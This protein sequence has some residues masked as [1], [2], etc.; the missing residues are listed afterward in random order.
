MNRIMRIVIGLVIITLCTSVTRGVLEPLTE[1]QKQTYAS[2]LPSLINSTKHSTLKAYLQSLAKQKPADSDTANLNAWLIRVASASRVAKDVNESSASQSLTWYAVPAMSDLM[3]LADRYPYDG[4]YQGDL[5]IVAARGEYEPV[6]FSLFAFTDLSKVELEVTDL[7]SSSGQTLSRDSVDLKVVK[8]WYQNATGWYSYFNDVGQVLVPELLL[9]DENLIRVDT[10]T[11]SNYARIKGPNGTREEWI[12]PPKDLD[13]NFD[14]Y[15]PGFEDAPTIQPVSLEAGA[16]K[17]FFL[18]VKVDSQ[19]RPGIYRGQVRVKAGN[20]RTVTIPLAVRVLPFELPLPMSFYDLKKPVI[21]SI[22]GAWPTLPVDHPAIKASLR[23]LREHNV[24]HTAP[25]LNMRNPYSTEELIPL[26][27]EAGFESKPI[28]H[29]HAYSGIPGQALSRP[30]LFEELHSFRRATLAWKEFYKKHFGHTEII[31]GFAD[32]PGVRSVMN[33]RTLWRMQ[34][35]LGVMNQLAGHDQIYNRA[36]YLM[37]L[38]QS[39]GYPDAEKRIRGHKFMGHSYMSFYAGQ[40]TGVENPQHVRRQHGLEGYLSGLNAVHNY[41]FAYG[42]WNDQARGI[43]KSFVLAYPVHNGLVDT[44]A[45]EGFR[46]GID[47]MRYATLLQTLA[48][49]AVKSTENSDL[50]VQG[51]KSLHWLSLVN[52]TTAELNAVRLEMI[53]QIL[54]LQELSGQSAN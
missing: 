33:L 1:D 23:N 5:N 3:R 29:R 54:L 37:D 9:H 46:E 20:Q 48:R 31:L 27:K 13:T 18:T 39:A 14:H 32:E 41:I 28:V 51:R 2:Q 53:R 43:Y 24:L 4:I 21:V 42:P 17:Q 38:H 25:G 26:F 12:N 16:F 52:G 19:A 47:D 40:H 35:E 11:Q 45:W 15:Q 22:M 8:I 30:I 44:M 49:E 6:S 50:F 36:G 34:K 7:T 10:R